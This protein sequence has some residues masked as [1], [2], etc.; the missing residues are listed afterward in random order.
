MEV[1]IMV[2]MILA[3]GEIALC[4][5]V[6]LEIF[7]GNKRLESKDK[8]AIV[9]TILLLGTVLKKNRE[10]LFVS[11]HMLVLCVLITCIATWF[12]VREN[13][14]SIVAVVS[15]Y[16]LTT[17]MIQMFLAFLS[18][19][20]LEQ[21][22]A[23]WIYYYASSLWKNGIYFVS[24]VIVGITFIVMKRKQKEPIDISR[25][26]K[27]LVILDC[28]FYF[29]WRQYQLM[30]DR[31]AMG[32]QEA[33]GVGVA[34]S[35]LTIVSIIGFI[36]MIFMKYSVIREENRNYLLRDKAY[37]ENL[38]EMEHALE[39]NR[40]MRHDMKNH[41]LVISELGEN[42]N[43]EELK[44]YIQKIGTEYNHL[45]HKVWTGNRMIDLIL[46]Q[47]K[48]LAEQKGT[49]CQI[50][51][52]LLPQIK[53]SDVELCSLFGNLFDNAIEACEKVSDKDR[54]IQV[55]IG[56]QQE[57]L[58]IH[59]SNTIGVKPVKEGNRFLS[60]KHDKELHGY[61]LK[62]VERI[63]GNHEGII[64]YEADDRTFTVEVTF[65]DT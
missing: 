45:G 3:F 34:V 17:S 19:L 33:E 16:Y 21:Q 55:K 62:S 54:Q 15:A 40:Q 43:W 24:L 23:D 6:L 41:F 27:I 65:F 29:V 18:M 11:Y 2:E 49:V 25:Y 13:I 35:L 39:M 59:I 31:I 37:Q 1:V 64:S 7:M 26:T 44:K 20:F 48:N 28:F 60:T 30:M 32:E 5:A 38:M 46:S 58:F 61:G 51:A 56:A 10:V 8:I 36:G 50:E 47:K 4:F 53:L 14:D 9:G 22:F 52:M 57:L 42:A 12:L 63:V